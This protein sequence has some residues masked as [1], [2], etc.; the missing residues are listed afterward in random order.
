ME[1]FVT[2]KAIKIIPRESHFEVVNFISGKCFRISA[3]IKFLLDDYSKKQLPLTHI[4]KRLKQAQHEEQKV[5]EMIAFLVRNEILA[6]THIDQTAQLTRHQTSAF[7]VEYID[8]SKITQSKVAFVG[9]PYGAGN[10]KNNLCR[11]F[12]NKFRDYTSTSMNLHN[13]YHDLRF[14][15]INERIN[16]N[17]LLK[18]IASNSICDLGNIFLINNEDSPKV[19]SK[20]SQVVHKILKKECFPFFLGGDHSVTYPVVKGFSKVYNEFQ[21]I[22]FDAHV[23][24]KNSE[25][26]N[27]YCDCKHMI[28]NHATVVNNILELPEVQKVVQ[29]GIRSLV[30]PCI[31]D[32]RVTTIWMDE[33]NSQIRTIRD[34]INFDLPLYITL[35]IDFFDPSIAPGTANPILH[36]AT[37]EQF[38]FIVNEAIRGARI[39]GADIVE[40]NPSLDVSDLTM[41]LASYVTIVLTNAMGTSHANKTADS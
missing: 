9:I 24:Y 23:D 7:G 27:F 38:C 11:E 15:T 12:P 4:R 5:N 37:F 14:E 32:E 28:M 30:R 1:T 3:P 10:P 20:I 18:L 8:L 25:V 19:I 22:Q 41:Q 6:P 36:G 2:S 21:I 39:I 13:T 29:I 35:D 16:F 17:P 34:A 33:A 40:V 26:Y 31:N